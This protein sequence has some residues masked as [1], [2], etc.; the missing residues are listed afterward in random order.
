[1]TIEEMLGDPIRLTCATM[2][3][4]DA[5]T[6]DDALSEADLI[7]IRHDL[8][9]GEAWMLFDMRNALQF[10]IP[11]A[12]AL[13]LRGVRSFD[14]RSGQGRREGRTTHYVL[15][16]RPSVRDGLFSVTLLCLGGLHI[17][18]SARSAE[19]LVGDVPGLPDTPPDY[20]DDDENTIKAGMPSWDKEFTLLGASFF[21]T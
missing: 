11:D 12:A 9:A 3:E 10:R 5:L 17:H 14:V 4:S 19:F 6:A 8:S 1:M 16:S 21:A 20:L 18:V 7:C 13:V 2:P 15:D